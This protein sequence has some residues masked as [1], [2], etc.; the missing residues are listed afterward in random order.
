MRT[1]FYKTQSGSLIRLLETK[2]STASEVITNHEQICTDALNQLNKG[3]TPKSKATIP[4]DLH[5]STMDIRDDGEFINSLMFDLDYIDQSKKDLYI[6]AFSDACNIPPSA[7]GIIDSGGGI[8][9]VLDLKVE[10][11]Q[12]DT[13]FHESYHAVCKSLDLMLRAKGLVIQKDNK[14][15]HF[16]PYMYI[17]HKTIRLPGTINAKY[18][19]PRMCRILQ[20][21]ASQVDFLECIDTIKKNCIDLMGSQGMIFTKDLSDAEVVL[22]GC[23]FLQ[24]YSNHQHEQTLPIWQAMGQ[25]YLNFKNENREELFLEASRLYPNFDQ[26]HF[27]SLVQGIKDNEL[28]S[29][30]CEKING[31]WGKCDSCKNFGKVKGPLQILGED[32]IV[33]EKD[34][35]WLFEEI[36]VE[37]KKDPVVKTYVDNAGLFRKYTQEYRVAINAKDG[38]F[39]YLD[40]DKGLWVFEYD[41]RKKIED[42]LRFFA[43]K[44]IKFPKGRGEVNRE[45]KAFTE[46]VLD[47]VCNVTKEEIDETRLMENCLSFENGM[48]NIV[49]C[50]YIGQATDKDKKLYITSKLPYSFDPKAAVPALWLKTL[51]EWFQGDQELIDQLGYTFAH[52][53]SDSRYF[54]QVFHYWYGDGGN[55]KSLAKKILMSLAKGST[56]CIKPKLITDQRELTPLVNALVNVSEEFSPSELKD[57][58]YDDLKNL[59]AGGEFDYSEKWKN[60]RTANNRAKFIFI[61]NNTF[62]ITDANKAMIR[63]IRA[64]PFT[65]DMEKVQLDPYLEEKLITKE[66][67][68]GILNW[69]ISY[70]SKLVA[71]DEFPNPEKCQACVEDFKKDNPVSEFL[72][73]EYI[74]TPKDLNGS[75]EKIKVKRRTLQL[76]FDLYCRYVLGHKYKVFSV[77]SKFYDEIEK[78]Y[79]KRTG[80]VL[81]E[82]MV[83]GYQ[84]YKGIGFDARKFV[85]DG[86]VNAAMTK[87]EIKA[88]DRILKEQEDINEGV[89]SFTAQHGQI[90]KTKVS[91]LGEIEKNDFS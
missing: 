16:D 32:A 81:V 73:S 36:K 38:I 62:K 70:V 72:D 78:T 13:F 29:Y 1:I 24:Y 52:V 90:E 41:A 84:H 91:R 45:K 22:N 2:Y 71:L 48:Y 43:Q 27:D 76:F 60:K 33:S 42:S 46:Y 83:K 53:L 66:N 57:D 21:N 82:C 51:S 86:V 12:T 68:S 19:P 20:G 26:D 50:A 17:P 47:E 85:N 7:I 63:R 34:G 49:T 74:L 4:E 35:F 37:G 44:K 28:S 58:F 11:K 15:T 55:G 31:L 56:S 5:Y 80:V 25:A 8:H 10:I 79:R 65:M 30:G 40:E 23:S 64:L 87:D 77:P 14:R 18:D 59:C 61:S 39:G 69:A 75:V 3:R 9:L 67:L 6:Q 89:F 88:L 54:F